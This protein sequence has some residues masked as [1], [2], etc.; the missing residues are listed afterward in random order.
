M[1][2][3]RKKVEHPGDEREPG[4]PKRVKTAHKPHPA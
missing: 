4:A 3:K 1:E 2:A